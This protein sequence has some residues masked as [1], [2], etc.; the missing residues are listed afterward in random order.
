M[1]SGFRID[2]SW[3]KDFDATKILAQEIV[4]LIQV[5]SDPARANIC[6]NIDT[7]T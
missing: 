1:S 6:S 7:I 4:S 2:E 3:V 5:R